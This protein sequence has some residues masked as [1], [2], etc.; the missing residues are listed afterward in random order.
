MVGL[1]VVAGLVI[2][3]VGLLLS[4]TFSSA[5]ANAPTVARVINYNDSNDIDHDGL[6]DA[7]EAYYGTDPKNPDSDGDGYLDGEEVMSGCNPKKIDIEGCQPRNAAGIATT[8]LTNQ[9]SDL[10]ATGLVAGALKDP[11]NNKDFQKNI[12][13]IG[14]Q[15]YLDF[16]DRFTPKSTRADLTI[17]N[18]NSRETV[19]SYI[20]SLVKILDATL[21]RS[22]DEQIEEMKSGLQLYTLAP[23][24]KN[25]VFIRLSNSFADSYQELLKLPV[26]ADWTDLHLKLLDSMGRFSLAYQ[27]ITDPTTDPVA[28]ILAFQKLVDEFGRVQ[29]IL[30][31]IRVKAASYN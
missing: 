8:N 18:D 25:P 2:G 15:A 14:A 17:L 6:S 12:G 28:N 4:Q 21:L 27:Y 13:L 20:D 19:A 23:Q 22:K 10:L 30:D 24:E 16:E 31:G 29:P 1:F 9:V 26:P 7:D 11:A 3:R 5:T